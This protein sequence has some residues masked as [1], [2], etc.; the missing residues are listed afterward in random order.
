VPGVGIV[1]LKDCTKKVTLKLTP[2]TVSSV[3]ETTQNTLERLD[4]T[5]KRTKNIRRKKALQEEFASLVSLSD[6]LRDYRNLF[7]S[8]GFI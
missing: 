5:I 3:F 4:K 1:V 6:Q 8:K 7:H 2:E